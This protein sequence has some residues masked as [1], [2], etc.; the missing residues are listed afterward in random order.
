MIEIDICLVLLLYCIINP[1]ITDL[2][3][4]LV[5]LGRCWDELEVMGR[6]SGEPPVVT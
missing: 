5:V 6:L 1:F 3:L 2:A 4:G